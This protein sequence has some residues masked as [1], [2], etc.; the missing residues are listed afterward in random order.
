MISAVTPQP[1]ASSAA[2]AAE[3][4]MW[5]YGSVMAFS[6]QAASSGVLKWSMW[7]TVRTQRPTALA[8]MQS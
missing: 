5:A 3:T 6:W 2:T 4:H 8:L 7:C 1:A